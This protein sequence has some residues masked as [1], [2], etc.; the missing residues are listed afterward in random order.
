MPD[1]VDDPD[2]EFQGGIG[3]C[4]V[5]IRPDHDGKVEFKGTIWNASAGTEIEVGTKVKIIKKVGL[6]LE[7]E[8]V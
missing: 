1:L 7:V 2:E 6:L 3:Q 5:K 8:P 4:S